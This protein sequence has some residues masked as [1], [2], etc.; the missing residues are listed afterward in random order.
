MPI[1]IHQ[2]QDTTTISGNEIVGIEFI[3]KN[4]WRCKKQLYCV[5]GFVTVVEDCRLWALQDWNS[6]T[7]SIRDFYALY[8]SSDSI[9]SQIA[10]CVAEMACVSASKL[11]RCGEQLPAIQKKFIKNANQH[12]WTSICPSCCSHDGPAKL[13][14]NERYPLLR[15]SVW[16]ESVMKRQFVY[17][18]C[19]VRFDA[20]Q[21]P[22]ET[23][24]HNRSVYQDQ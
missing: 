19:T 3:S 13:I 20:P 10:D 7:W 18:P 15:R 11:S 6:G 4:C 17:R 2:R 22:Y 12:L 24:K 8:Q 9:A 23:I 21:M 16:R 14:E 1:E 5:S